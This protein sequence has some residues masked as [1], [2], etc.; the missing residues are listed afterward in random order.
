MN[1]I[2]PEMQ[3]RQLRRRRV[4]YWTLAAALCLLAGISYSMWKCQSYRESRRK[5]TVLTCECGKL[6]KRIQQLASARGL[7]EQWQGR[8]V[9]EKRLGAYP[10]MKELLQ[11]IARCTPESIY[12]R[13]FKCHLLND[14]KGGA[15]IKPAKVLP[16][17]AELFV[18]KESAPPQDKLGEE[19]EPLRFFRFELQGISLDYDSIADLLN[20]LKGSAF[21]R[22]IELRET[23]RSLTEAEGYHFIIEAVALPDL[24]IEGIEYADM[25][26]AENF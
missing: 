4:R 19:T 14:E 15:A 17:A 3:L 6:E 7:L 23:Q 13:D 1:L 24:L 26:K 16:K 25:P 21:L 22:Q 20:S 12:Y 9:F 10:P 2:P 5:K 8:L 18:L 11:E